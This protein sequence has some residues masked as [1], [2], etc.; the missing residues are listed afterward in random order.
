MQNSRISPSLTQVLK[1]TRRDDWRPVNTYYNSRLMARLSLKYWVV[2]NYCVDG[3]VP[4]D[5]GGND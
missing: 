3:F 1:Q 2:G 4:V 5:F